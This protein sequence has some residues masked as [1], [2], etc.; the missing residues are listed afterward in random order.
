MRVI[1]GTAKGRRLKTV[2]GMTTRP[3][4]DRVKESL[5]NIIK[6]KLEDNSF[7]DLYAGTGNIGI[8][9][10][11][12]GVVRVVFVERD[13]QA[14]K[15]LRE[16]LQLTNFQQNVE[17][18]QQD[19]MTALEILGKKKR[20]FDLIFLD[21]PYYEGLEEKTLASICSNKVLTSQGLV[22]IEHSRKNTLP[23]TVA[24]LQ[25]IR[26]ENYGDTAISF[27]RIREDEQ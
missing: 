26:T 8:E 5:F 17:I 10:L 2:K 25:L 27:Y 21:P 24:S 15:I 14:I 23:S 6:E 16:N 1:A 7:L 12:R 9:A 19:V 3:T 20:S 22:I 11:S 13:K 18:Y 4:A